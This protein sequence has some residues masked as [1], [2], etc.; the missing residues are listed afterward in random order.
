MLHYTENISQELEQS[1]A[2]NQDILSVFIKKN[3]VKSKD[4][5]VFIYTIIS[6]LGEPIAF[7][8]TEYECIYFA[9][10]NNL[11]YQFIH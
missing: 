7:F 1:E 4:N 5:A 8:D 3:V 9:A 10:S 2:F 11:T 6:E